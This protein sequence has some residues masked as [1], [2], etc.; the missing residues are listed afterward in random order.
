MKKLIVML[1]IILFLVLAN[2]VFSQTQNKK[3]VVQTKNSCLTCHKEDDNMPDDY[4]PNNVHASVGLNCVDCHGGDSTSDDED[5]AMSKA[6]GFVGAPEKTEIPQFCGKCHSN[7]NYMRKYNPRAET[8]QVSQY[9]TS[10]HGK[11]LKKGDENVAACT[12]CHTAHSIFKVNNPQSTVYAL[13]VPGTCN[14]CHGDAKLI[15]KYKLNPNIYEEYS[16]SVHGIALLKNKDTGAPACNDCHGNH[17]AMPP[18]VNSIANVCGLCHVNNLKYF[19]A[20]KMGKAFK[21]EDYHGCEECHGNH[22]IKKPTDDFIGVSDKAVC[23]N[24]HDEG[25]DGYIVAETIHGELKKL[26][27]MY[28][29]AKVKL[30]EVKKIGMDDVDISFILK[31]VHQ[32][33]IKARTKVHTFDTVQV[34]KVVNTGL[35]TAFK[36]IKK[37]DDEISDYHTRTNGFGI[38][39]GIFLILIILIYLK[40]KT[41]EKKQ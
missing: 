13:N 41:I 6:K 26:T 32:S 7:I 24:C 21:E 1:N 30:S 40:L 23:I 27:S 3:N 25:E 11:Q 39:T 38:A 12:D 17:G 5:I 10:V 35:K 22:G 9:Y 20:S 4:N 29:S 33:I 28:D 34:A 37:A 15:S 19:E 14:K 36:A 2:S 31:D 18:G 16:N 8:D